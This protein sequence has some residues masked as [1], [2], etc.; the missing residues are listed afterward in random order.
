MSHPAEL[1][2]ENAIGTYNALWA[3]SG[4]LADDP[5]VGGSNNWILTFRDGLRG[6]LA[7][8]ET[9]D[10][11]YTELHEFQLQA[12]N[13]NP[14]EWVVHCE[15]HAAV[16]FFGMDSAIECF[17]FAM[18]AIGFLKFPDDF[19]DIAGEVIATDWS[20]EHPRRRSN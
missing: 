16:I 11:N 19:L 2:F 14:N 5:K 12:R 3:L 9:V 10:R 7:R 4:M 17:V 1:T 13:G 8:V 18:N 6:M 15:S 20:E